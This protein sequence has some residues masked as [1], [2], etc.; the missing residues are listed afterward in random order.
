MSNDATALVRPD[1]IALGLS[2]VMAAVAISVAGWIAAE[3]LTEV[4][5]GHDVPVELRLRSDQAEL[6]FGLDR[7]P[8]ATL[9]ATITSITVPVGD[10]S[11]VTLFA[12]WADPVVT[13]LAVAAGA[14]VAASFLR[15][16]SL[17]RAFERGSARLVFAVASIAAAHWILHTI[18]AHLGSVDVRSMMFDRAHEG[19]PPAVDLA[20]VGWTL[21]LF[22]VGFAFTLG[23]K[24]RRET[25]GLV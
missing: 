17:G 25:A 8:T 20:P 16:I 24:L 18:L 13:F 9:G 19:G 23:E 22:A 21:F 1:R 3:R 15:R 10:P 11:P 12:L 2:I 7:Q 4:A 14:T 5:P 6:L